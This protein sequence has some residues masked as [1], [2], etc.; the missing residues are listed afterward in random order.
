MHVRVAAVLSA[1]LALAQP[2]LADRWVFVGDRDNLKFGYEPSGSKNFETLWFECESETKQILVSAAVGNKRPRS[3]AASVKITAGGK[4][5]T[6][7]GP[8]AQEEFNGVYVVDMGVAR[9]HPIFALLTSGQALAYTAPGWKRLG[10][11]TT[12]QKDGA[13]K[14]LAACRR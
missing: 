10:L 8:V 1:L 12:G 11:A 5:A 4:S 7:A 14:F 2:A 13:K 9:D 3:G 6:L